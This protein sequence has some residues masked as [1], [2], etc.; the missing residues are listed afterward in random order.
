MR[1]DVG[2]RIQLYHCRGNKL[3]SAND[4][5]EAVV[6]IDTSNLFSVCNG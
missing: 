6:I 2:E 4:V 5:N 3:V 1:N